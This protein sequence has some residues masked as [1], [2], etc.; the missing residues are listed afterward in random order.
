MSKYLLIYCVRL[1][2]S[3]ANDCNFWVTWQFLLT[4]FK[5]C[6]IAF[7]ASEHYYILSSN[8]QVI[9]FWLPL[10]RVPQGDAATQLYYINISSL[11]QSWGMF[12]IVLI[13]P[14]WSLTECCCQDKCLH[15]SCDGLL[16][17]PGKETEIVPS[18][19]IVYVFQLWSRN[20]WKTF[21]LQLS[22]RHIGY[23]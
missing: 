7:R 8:A 21:T 5:N 18:L 15:L 2:W 1:G 19:S 22:K 11:G 6:Y 14:G 4:S 23:L 13:P 3:Y 17:C 10:L 9:H 16:L 20:P 12:Y